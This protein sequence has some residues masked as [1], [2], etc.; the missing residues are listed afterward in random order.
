MTATV[1]GEVNHPG[2]YT[3]NFADSAGTNHAPM[4]N[5][6]SE[7]HGVEGAELAF[8]VHATDPDGTKPGLAAAPLRDCH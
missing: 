2:T 7:Q 3:V 1:R 4:L 6:I 5:P 8:T